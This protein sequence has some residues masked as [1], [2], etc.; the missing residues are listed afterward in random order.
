MKKHKEELEDEIFV[1][2]TCLLDENHFR[3][4][5]LNNIE[6]RIGRVAYYIDGKIIKS[7][8]TKPL[9]IKKNS[10]ETYDKLMMK[11]SGFTVEEGENILTELYGGNFYE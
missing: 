1:G 8:I 2:N 6:Y 9:F 4:F 7:N 3:L 10:Y 5:D 11:L